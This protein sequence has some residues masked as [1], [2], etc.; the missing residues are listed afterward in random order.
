MSPIYHVIYSGM[1]HSGNLKCPCYRGIGNLKK[2]RR[3]DVGNNE[4]E[5]LVSTAVHTVHNL[6]MV[7]VFLGLCTS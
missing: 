6:F 4:I 2:L 3:L 7:L 1:S 5:V